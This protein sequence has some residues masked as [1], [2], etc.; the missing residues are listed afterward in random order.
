MLTPLSPC[1][2]RYL[3]AKGEARLIDIRSTGEFAS[4]WIDGAENMP[5]PDV[6]KI[7]GDKKVVFMCLSGARVTANAAL[8][9]Q[10]AGGEAYALEG[11]MIGWKRAGLP[12]ETTAKPGIL[13]ALFGR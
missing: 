4:E 2:L 6:P 3:L 12:V 13:G 1:D 9:A 10:A 11:S 7:E 8:L 5:L